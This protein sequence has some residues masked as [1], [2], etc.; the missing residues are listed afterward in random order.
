MPTPRLARP[1][2]ASPGSLT[3]GIAVTLVIGG[4]AL[5]TGGGPRERT[6]PRRDLC[7]LPAP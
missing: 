2:P 4:A 7:E 6:L 3:L 5:L 1:L